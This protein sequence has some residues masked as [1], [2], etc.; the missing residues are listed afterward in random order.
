MLLVKAKLPHVAPRVEVTSKPFTISVD[1][2]STEPEKDDE[3]E[4]GWREMRVES[5]GQNIATPPSGWGKQTRS[6][7]EDL[8]TWTSVTPQDW[9]WQ[10]SEVW[11]R[12]RSLLDHVCITGNNW[13]LPTYADEFSTSDADFVRSKSGLSSGA[14]PA[15]SPRPP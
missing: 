6:L 15:A 8:P 4:E 9:N 12:C 7:A 14:W 3:G 2:G 5:V 11:T 13:G 10:A 1:M